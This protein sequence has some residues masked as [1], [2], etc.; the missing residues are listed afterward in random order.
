MTI[1]LDEVVRRS[2]HAASSMGVYYCST[3]QQA[4]NVPKRKRKTRDKLL[5][6]TWKIVNKLFQKKVK[7]TKG[8][9]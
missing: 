2:V 8:A 6:C 7:N 9:P 5:K 3:L 1:S 4:S